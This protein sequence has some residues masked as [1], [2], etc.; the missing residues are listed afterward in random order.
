[1][2]KQWFYPLH[3]IRYHRLYYFSQVYEEQ[4]NH[5]LKI[6]L[7][8]KYCRAYFNHLL[9]AVP[10][11]SAL[12]EKQN[13]F[14]STKNSK[15][16]CRLGGFTWASNHSETSRIQAEYCKH[17]FFLTSYSFNKV[18]IPQSY[19][20]LIIR[21]LSTYQNSYFTKLR[22]TPQFLWQAAY[23]Q[24]KQYSQVTYICFE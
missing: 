2:V 8:G 12:F 5:L 23:T 20:Y 17:F 15:N 18:W 21:F 13:A 6:E 9:R 11:R 16:T 24:Y 1:M 3:T 22:V 4:K 19:F 14:F 7:M 10:T